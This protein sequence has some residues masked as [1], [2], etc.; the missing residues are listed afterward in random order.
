MIVAGYDISYS[1][2]DEQLALACIS[3]FDQAGESTTS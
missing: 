3:V 1:K 2:F